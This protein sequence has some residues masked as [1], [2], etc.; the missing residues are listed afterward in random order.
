MSYRFFSCKTFSKLNAPFIFLL[1][2][3]QLGICLKISCAK[4]FHFHSIL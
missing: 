1:L 4:G 3:I 2:L